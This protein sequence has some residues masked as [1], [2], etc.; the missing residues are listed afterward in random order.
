MKFSLY[1]VAVW[2]RGCEHANMLT[3][4]RDVCVHTHTLKVVM[5]FE[6]QEKMLTLAKK[7]HTQKL[8]IFD[9]NNR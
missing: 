1:Y 7:I 4:S 8:L 6:A 9:T 3:F 2:L 5:N